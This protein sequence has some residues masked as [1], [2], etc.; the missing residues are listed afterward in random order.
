MDENIGRTK[1][2]SLD[3]GTNDQFIDESQEYNITNIETPSAAALVV[4]WF[5]EQPGVAYTIVGALF[6]TLFVAA[7]IKKRKRK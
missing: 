4:Q 7:A 5:R 2:L 6:L 3:F 1:I